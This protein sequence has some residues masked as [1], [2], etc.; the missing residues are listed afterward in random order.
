M[1]HLL[2]LITFLTI[3]VTSLAQ[4]FTGPKDDIDQIL[5]NIET[6]SSQVMAGD[7]VAVTANYTTDAKIFPNNQDILEGTEAIKNYWKPRNDNKII[8]HKVTP[9][10]IKILGNEAYDYGYYE[11]T[12][13]LADGTETSWRGKYVITWKKVDQAWKIYLDIWNSIK[14]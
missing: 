2:L 6:F 7:Y 5:K 13:R 9:S 10:E 11:G 14:S 4:T 12:T 1:K 3:T 8:Y